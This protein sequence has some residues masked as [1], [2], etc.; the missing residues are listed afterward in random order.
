V[1]IIEGLGQTSNLLSL[2]WML[3]RS[4]AA[5]GLDPESI[6]DGL[7]GLEN[8]GSNTTAKAL[9]EILDRDLERTISRIGLSAAVDVQV[10]GRVCAG[11]VLHYEVERTHL[12]GEL[13]RFAVRA[14]VGEH[15]VLSGTMVGARIKG[16]V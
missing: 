10:S 4:L 2:F 13:S 16:T 6:C 15:V 5:Q 12:L 8:H 9:L 3:E 7:K 11:E 1:Y 14:C